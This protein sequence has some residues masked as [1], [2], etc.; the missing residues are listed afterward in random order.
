M[1][2]QCV[3]CNTI[4]DSGRYCPRCGSL[5]IK[6]ENRIIKIKNHNFI[7]LIVI[8]S[9]CFLAILS[10]IYW[11]FSGNFIKSYLSRFL[12]AK[13]YEV[14]VQPPSIRVWGTSKP[15]FSLQEL[16]DLRILFESKQF[17]SL[18]KTATDI[19]TAFERDPS[20]EYQVYDFFQIFDTVHP[21][22][23]ALLDAWTEYAPSHFA[24]YLAR[25]QYYYSK[26]WASRGHKYAS[27]TSAEQFEG[28]HRFFQKAESDIDTALAINPR[29]LTAYTIRIGIYNAEG[30]DANENTTFNKTRTLFPN[31]F[32]IYN[33]MI[34]SKLPRWGGSYAEMEKIALQALE[35]IEANPELYMLFGQI[36][37]DQA[38]TLREEKQ[39]DRALALYSKAISYGEHHSFFQERAR[40]YRYMKDYVHAIE[41]IDHSISLRPT[42]AAPYRLRA[43]IYIEMKDM[44]SA[45][46]DIRFM[47]QQFP[48]SKDVQ[49][50]TGWAAKQMLNHGH[51][52]FKNNLE[53]AIA[54]YDMALDINPQCAEAFYWRGVAYSK[55][56]KTELAYSDLKQAI[57]Y[58]PRHFETYR[59]LDYILAS[60]LKWDEII[61]HWNQFLALEPGNAKAYLERAGAYRRTGDMKSALA[62]LHQACEL[63]EQE[64]CRLHKQYE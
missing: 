19:Q 12:S 27:E 11:L 59:M 41:D 32:L 57:R 33:R 48:W 29:L 8:G 38:W 55:L 23:Q 2:S 17:D 24:P 58:N 31:S 54:K 40:T 42:L 53:Q 25:A 64:A 50:L 56:K 46:K 5:L 45:M 4:Y 14:S 39:Y 15:T 30:E 43:T 28:M 26:G 16:R 60:Q 7:I 34:N 18:T 9:L 3:N 61:A 62:D 13:V 6:T 51:A 1:P 47:T 22:Y 37:V 63:G 35:N 49:E 21:E 20:Y 52:V 36:Y 10:L 44:D